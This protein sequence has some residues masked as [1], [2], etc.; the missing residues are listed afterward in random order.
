MTSDTQLPPFFY[1][2]SQ[3]PV[4]LGIRTGSG[5]KSKFYNSKILQGSKDLQG[6]GIHTTYEHTDRI[7]MPKHMRKF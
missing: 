5:L 6:R 3:V 1:G 2:G 7:M 4:N